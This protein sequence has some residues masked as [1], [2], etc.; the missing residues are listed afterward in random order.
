MHKSGKEDLKKHAPLDPASK[1]VMRHAIDV[2]GISARACDRLIRVS[3][4]IADLAGSTDVQQEHLIEALN[5]RRTSAL[6]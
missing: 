3:R 6:S 4:T 2:L 5:Y 1:E